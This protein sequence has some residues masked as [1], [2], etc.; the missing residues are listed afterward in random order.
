MDSKSTL[1]AKLESREPSWSRAACRVPGWSQYSERSHNT[2]AFC[3]PCTP[4]ST[5]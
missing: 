1:V 3:P 2:T 4:T 5:S